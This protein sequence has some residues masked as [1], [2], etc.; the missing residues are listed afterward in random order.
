MISNMG[1]LGN[2]A[3]ANE[4]SEEAETRQAGHSLNE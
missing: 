3:L 4:M 2:K 1:N